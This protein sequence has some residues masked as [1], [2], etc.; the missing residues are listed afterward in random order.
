[1]ARGGATLS[2]SYAVFM[3]YGEELVAT[4]QEGRAFLC[5]KARFNLINTSRKQEQVEKT[6]RAQVS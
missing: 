4:R 5:L 3:L 1:M 6:I 2:A